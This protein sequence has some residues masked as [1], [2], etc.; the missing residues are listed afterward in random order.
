MVQEQVKAAGHQVGGAPAAGVDSP[1]TPGRVATGRVRQA[2]HPVPV[3]EMRRPAVGRRDEAEW[4]FVTKA[5]RRA[6]LFVF[7]STLDAPRTHILSGVP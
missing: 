3:A 5:N 4:W 1:A 7:Q 2:A 6:Y